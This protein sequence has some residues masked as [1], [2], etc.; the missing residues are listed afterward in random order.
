M[1]GVVLRV[2][3]RARGDVGAP[4]VLWALLMTVVLFMLEA[5]LGPRATTFWVGFSATALLG[6]YLGCR[7]RVGAVFFAPMV[8]WF[9]AW[10]FLI[11]AAMIEH[12]FFAG[13]FVGLF[14]ITIGWIGV[15]LLEVAVLLVVSSLVR[16]LRASAPERDVV[17]FA[18]GQREE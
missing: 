3:E 8:N 11:V 10:P 9:F 4:V 16:Q 12:G 13:I 1:N 5:R 2:R 18:P 7:R 17:I 6:A 15:A 14:F